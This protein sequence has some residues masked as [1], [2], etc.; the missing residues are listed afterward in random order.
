MSHEKDEVELINLQ[1]PSESKKINQKNNDINNQKERFCQK[2]KSLG[3]QRQASEQV[4]ISKNRPRQ[5]IFIVIKT[6]SKDK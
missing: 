5:K 1:L 2:M 6:L 4:K 3:S